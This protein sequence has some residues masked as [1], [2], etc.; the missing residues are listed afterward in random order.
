MKSINRDS[1]SSPKILYE[2]DLI[3]YKETLQAELKIRMAQYKEDCLTIKSAIGVA[4]PSKMGTSSREWF[5][6]L[7]N[8]YRNLIILDTQIDLLDKLIG[9]CKTE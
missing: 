8:T 6:E 2:T 1:N 9:L 3:A 7:E 4:T 5:G